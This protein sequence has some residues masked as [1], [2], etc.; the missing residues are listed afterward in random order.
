MENKRIAVLGS[1][2]SIGTQTMDAAS[3]LGCEF[4]FISANTS[5]KKLEEQVRMFKPKAC[6][7]VDSSKKS[8]LEAAL[9]D[10][11]V[12]IYSGEESLLKLIEEADY[13]VIE[14]SISGS[15][16][17]KAAIAAAKTGKRIAMANKEAIISCGDL[18]YKLVG[19]NNSELIPVDSEHSAIFQCLLQ[20]N[21]AYLNKSADTS[22]IKKIL[23]TASGGPFFGYTKEELNKVTA[24]EALAH[25]TWKMG[26]KITI[27]S[28]TLMN[29][30]F[31]IIE[32]SRLFGVNN[33]QIEVL[34][35]RQSIIHSMVEYKDNSIIAELSQPDMRH[36]IRYAITYPNRAE[37]KEESLDFAKL[38]KLT[39]DKP[40]TKAFPL[41]DTARRVLDLGKNAPSALISADEVAVEKF[42]KDEIKFNDIPEIVNKTLDKIKLYDI[43]SVEDVI[44]TYN[45]AEEIAKNIK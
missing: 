6:V 24:K 27:D 39:F 9:K 19:E 38:S 1:T 16:G 37:V 21:A 2:G 30:G 42:M 41:L 44:S 31:E 14:H 12:K 11:D 8:L 22:K 15:A 18:I 13:D 32:A 40:D 3:T 29:K 33:N 35:H 43:N 10:V 45:M 5:Y 20:S 7:I 17:L 28:A 34:I 25:P 23:L 4:S 36:C 26:P